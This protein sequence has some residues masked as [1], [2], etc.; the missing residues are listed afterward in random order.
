M[1]HFKMQ[2]R[3]DFVRQAIEA[4]H[5]AAVHIAK[6]SCGPYKLGLA[7]NR[8]VNMATLIFDSAEQ[9]VAAGI[10]GTAPCARQ[11]LF[12]SGSVCVD[13]RIQPKPG[14]E[15]VVLVG[16]LMDS[17]HPSHGLGGVPVS[18]LCGGDTVLHKK[19]NDVGEFDFGFEDPRDLQ[20]AFGLANR[21]VLFVAVPDAKGELPAMV[22]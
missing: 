12:R 22:T 4:N 1:E 18:L 6:S 15:G 8:N 11:L 19:T 13:M 10:R 21:N 3:I 5:T 9:A 17:L 7:E 2:N 14:T 16:Q 20:L